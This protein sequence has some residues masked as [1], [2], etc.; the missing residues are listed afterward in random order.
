MI[1]ENLKPEV[2]TKL[3]D[4]AWEMSKGS[5]SNDTR[6]ARME[7]WATGMKDNLKALVVA[8]EAAQTE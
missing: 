1:F 5:N 4:I 6:D 8:C 3:L 2:Q 7:K